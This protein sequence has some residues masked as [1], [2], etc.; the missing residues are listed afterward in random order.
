[1]F[2]ERARIDQKIIENLDLLNNIVIYEPNGAFEVPLS[3]T[4]NGYGFIVYRLDFNGFYI[5]IFNEENSI[6]IGDENHKMHGYYE[7]LDSALSFVLF[8]VCP[9]DLL[10]SAFEFNNFFMT[11]KQYYSSEEE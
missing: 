3:I 4:I 10:K 8:R 11:D 6:M 5:S 1:M 9:N 2:N 7:D